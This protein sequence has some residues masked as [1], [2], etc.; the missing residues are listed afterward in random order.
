M[1]HDWISAGS[2]SH[3]YKCTNCGSIVYFNHNHGREPPP[4]NKLV[5]LPMHMADELLDYNY[6]SCDFITTFMVHGE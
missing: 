3:W 4:R 6:Y 1:E 2:L 5:N